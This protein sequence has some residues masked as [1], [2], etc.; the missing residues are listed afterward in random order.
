[1]Q[2]RQQDIDFHQYYSNGR[3]EELKFRMDQK[4]YPPRR[5]A[6]VKAGHKGFF[7]S[8]RSLD[9]QLVCGKS[10]VGKITIPHSN[11]RYFTES[12]TRQ[13]INVP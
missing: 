2:I 1:M 12:F 13:T 4:L 6:R 3:L 9:Y 5:K 7:K 10:Y 11:G 8:S